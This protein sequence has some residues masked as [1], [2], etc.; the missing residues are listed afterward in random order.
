MAL[1]FRF[2]PTLL[3][4][5]VSGAFAAPA[6]SPVEVTHGDIRRFQDVGTSA[7]DEEDN[8]RRLSEHLQA[9]GR[10]YLP[11][12]QTLKVELLDVD[13]A[14]ETRPQV[15][16][17][18][19]VRVARGGADWPRI[20]LR[21]TLTGAD[22]STLRSAEESVADMN[23]LRHIPRAKSDDPL[24]HEKRMLEGWFKARFAGAERTDA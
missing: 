12:G 14:G 20:Q 10:R 18:Q 24:R 22:G 8:V 21:Y 13:L 2:L 1:R 5:A 4:V 17:G 15:R 7:R 6:A 9:L 23:Y 16:A 11:A 3:L 19:D